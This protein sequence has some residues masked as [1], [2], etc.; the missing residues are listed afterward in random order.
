MATACAPDQLR[1]DAPEL[2]LNAVCPYYTMYP[3]SFPLVE[4]AGT[5]PGETVLDP[6]C[7]R[8]TTLYAARLR[9]LDSVGI[10]LNPVAVAIA[11][12]KLAATSPGRVIALAKRL[13]EANANAQPPEGRFW[14]LAF[15]EATLRSVCALRAGL[16]EAGDGGTAALL[17]AV[18]LGALHGPRNKGIPSYLSNQM[19]RSYA[20]KPA[21]AVRFWEKHKL[22]PPE[23]D[24]LDVLRRRTVRVLTT[25]LPPAHGRVLLGDAR[26]TLSQTRRRFT[27][28]VTSPPYLGMRTY[29]PDQWLRHWALGGEPAPSYVLHGQISSQHA[30]T[31]SRDLAD[32]WSAVASSCQRGARMTIRFGALPSIPVEPS[33]LLV[34]SLRRSGAN[35]QVIDERPAGVPRDG[36]RQA[37]QFG[38]VR[39]TPVVE[40]D[41]VA[42]LHA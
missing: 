33:D 13:I 40:V 30:E 22:L 4:L 20:T 3:L 16:I 10:D 42:V 15:H 5:S 32:V 11:R 6:F 31:F 8:G 24:V 26:T 35:W 7:G 38:R 25:P 19:P 9:G 27:R 23:I 29:L 12:A 41:V 18:F 34:D 21:P 39:S 28:V 2:R 17:R 14:T 1:P 36:R 37:E